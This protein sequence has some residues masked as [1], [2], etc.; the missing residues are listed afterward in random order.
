[1][2]GFTLWEGESP[3][4]S[5][6]IACV[7]VSSHNRKTGI[8][9]QTWIIK[10]DE[11]PLNAI[12]S[13]TDKSICGACPHRSQQDTGR[14]TCYVIPPVIG[15]VFKQYKAGAYPFLSEFFPMEFL[16]LGAYGDP[17]MVPFELTKTLTEFAAKH[18]G[19]THQWKESWF[20]KRFLALVSCSCENENEVAR[21]QEFG[22][23]AFLVLQV[24][25]AKPKNLIECPA[26]KP[27]Q[28]RTGKT[29]TCAECA[30]CSGSSSKFSKS[31]AIQV[32]GASKAFYRPL[33]LVT[34]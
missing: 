23:K 9:W 10:S 4:D 26:A 6:P 7:L 3:V 12:H 5:K 14:R 13:G 24:G 31:I 27:Y 29:V 30:L 2:P 1:M 8:S 15:K 17:A 25:Q 16:R 32:H 18:T 22:G 20:D 34:S 28:E 19:Y 33:Q 11:H 21:V